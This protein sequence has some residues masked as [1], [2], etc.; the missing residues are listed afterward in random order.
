M[1]L[2]FYGA[3]REVTGS[4][5][6]LQVG[7]QRLVIECG[8]IQG[9]P[10]HER[11]N[12][13][14]FPFD[15]AA[16]DAVVLTH[17]S[18]DHSG[19]PPLLLDQGFQGPIYTHRATA[20]LCRILWEDAGDLNE[21]EAVWENRKRERKGLPPVTPLYTR[22]TARLTQAQFRS[23]EYGRSEAILPGVTLTL[24]D[25]GHI[26]GSAIIELAL[27]EEAGTPFRL[28]F[29]GDPGTTVRLQTLFPGMGLGTLADF[30]GQPHG[31]RGHRGLSSSSPAV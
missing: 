7:Q 20:D 16:L 24:R 23:L 27:L 12:R 29:S 3:T 2:T 25:A 19:R 14:P 1:Q 9:T 6:W 22:A 31:H 15:P 5:Y 10:H 21:Q 4:C 11:H 30:S 26:L 13:E 18:L 28:V 17:A 8:L